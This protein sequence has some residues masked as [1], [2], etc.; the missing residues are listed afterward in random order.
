[1]TDHVFFMV[2]Q[3]KMFGFW[4]VFLNCL[5]HRSTSSNCNNVVSVVYTVFII[6]SWYSKKLDPR[7]CPGPM[8]VKN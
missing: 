8:P 2:M 1:M 3:L 7:S 5:Y 6:L 4:F